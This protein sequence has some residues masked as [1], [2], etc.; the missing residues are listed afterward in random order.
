MLSIL[1][2]VRAKLLIAM[3][4]THGKELNCANPEGVE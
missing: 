2:P 4:E 1:Q 3:G